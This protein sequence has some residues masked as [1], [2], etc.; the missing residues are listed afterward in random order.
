MPSQPLDDLNDLL[1]PPPYTPDDVLTPPPFAFSE[2]PVYPDAAELPIRTG[3]RG[4]YIG[5][6][7]ESQ[8]T[9]FSSTAAHFGDRSCIFP[10][11]G[12]VLQY[13]LIT[14]PN[15]SPEDLSYPQPESPY[16]A[17]DVTSQDWATFVNY[18]LAHNL[19][20]RN[21]DGRRN[22]DEK[23][24]VV[25]GDTPEY[26]QKIEATVAEWNERF[27]GPR[28]IRIHAEFPELSKPIPIGG[29][30][31]SSQLNP[32]AP[33]RVSTPSAPFVPSQPVSTLR[34][35]IP[36]EPPASYRRFP[37]QWAR[38]LTGP[39]RAYPERP[40][41]QRGD[42]SAPTRRRRSS[43]SSTSSSSSSSSDSSVDSIS[44]SDISGADVTGVR[45]T[46]AAFRLDPTRHNDAAGSVRQLR[47]NLRSQ[48]P[49]RGGR[50]QMTR[51][52]KAELHASKR[53]INAEVKALVREVKVSRREARNLRRE[54]KR[55]VKWERKMGRRERENERKDRHAERRT[56]RV[57]ERGEGRWEGRGTREMG[58]GEGRC[59][60]DGRWEGRGTIEMG[61]AGRQGAQEAREAGKRA[62]EEGLR[63]GREQREAGMRAREEGL[64]MGRTGRANGRQAREQ[65]MVAQ[66]AWLAGPGMPAL[67]DDEA[68]MGQETGVL[69]R[70]D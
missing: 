18:L 45:Q 28:G 52:M 32:L 12:D 56:E 47:D 4:G 70:D 5:P 44:S 60:R 65:R 20:T 64:R 41:A 66:Q 69:A 68:G 14:C 26:R 11:P 49:G 57:G 61:M 31:Y 16:R 7:Q 35:P 24:D 54:R 29:P 2:A 30:G 37:F 46:L 55:E 22:R 23:T 62:R 50:R 17:R 38:G 8:E 63:L 33:Y 21:K 34:G 43:V 15:M 40:Q 1:P 19:G 10:Y 9:P 36:A 39:A 48:R 13:H 59:W 67:A 6:V 25:Q 58:R 51:E 42:E 3:I 27:F 53:E